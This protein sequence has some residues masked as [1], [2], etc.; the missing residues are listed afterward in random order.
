M[1][2]HKPEAPVGVPF[3]DVAVTIRAEPVVTE[4]PVRRVVLSLGSN[5]GDRLEMLQGAV[6]ALTDTPDLQVRRR[7][8]GLRDRS[9]RRP[10]P[11][12]LPQRRPR[13][14][15]PALA[16]DPARAGA[17]DRERLRPGARRAVGTA[18]PRRRPGRGRRP[19]R[20]RA[21]PAAAAPAGRRAR[22]SCWCR[23]STSTRPP[24]SRVPAG[25]PTWS[26]GST[27]P[28]YAAA[29]TWTWWCRRDA[30]PCPG[31][32]MRPTRIRVLVALLLGVGGGDVGR[33]ADHAGPWRGAAAA[34]LDRT[35]GFIALLAI[36]V[37]ATALGLRARL[38]RPGEAPAPA[39]DGPDGRAGQGQ[40]ARRADRRRA[41]RRLPAGAAA[42]AGDR[43][44]P[45]TGRCS[46]WWRCWPSSASRSAGLLLERTCRVPPAGTDERRSLRPAPDPAYRRSVAQAVAT[47]SSS[48]A[49][50]STPREVGLDR[51]AQRLVQGRRGEHADEAVA[52][53]HR[54]PAGVVLQHL[55]ERRLERLAPTG[56]QASIRRARSAT[57][58]SPVVVGGRSSR[59]GRPASSSTTAQRAPAGRSDA[60]A[61]ATRSV[62]VHDRRVLEVGR[63][64]RR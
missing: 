28:A 21:R 33:A 23:G 56:T 30:R 49:S 40:R 63:L 51:A 8:P 60:A 58:P 31:A 18:H 44:P 11:A 16:A 50:G 62:E 48:T 3:E 35:R 22:A 10:G 39:V 24:S 14:R 19:G 59:A 64:D 5:L 41:L 32:P 53:E 27:G 47:V 26:S 29:T 36:V 20:R 12:R 6:D 4:Q 42:R 25:S 57:V 7:L 17:G 61:S 1:T 34:D 37:L 43:V 54:D 55:G 15:G 9:G 45:R 2:V 52:V 38:D 46:A 13:R